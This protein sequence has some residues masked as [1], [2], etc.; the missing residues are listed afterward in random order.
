MAARRSTTKVEVFLF[1]ALRDFFFFF[2]RDFTANRQICRLIQIRD[3]AE[4]HDD[5]SVKGDQGK[6]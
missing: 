6:V 1:L 4:K 5:S 2:M 3:V